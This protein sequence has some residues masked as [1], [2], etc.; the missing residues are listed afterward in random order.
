MNEIKLI[1]EKLTTSRDKLR[2][3]FLIGIDNEKIEIE[4]QWEKNN[5]DIIYGKSDEI[6]QKIYDHYNDVYKLRNKLFD[7]LSKVPASG[8][9]YFYTGICNSEKL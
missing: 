6:L 9:A 3:T 5:P 8:N 7:G 4:K 2:L 1:E